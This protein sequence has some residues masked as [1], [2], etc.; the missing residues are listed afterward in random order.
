[1]KTRVVTDN[2][3]IKNLP[4]TGPVRGTDGHVRGT[5]GPV[6]GTSPL[7]IAQNPFN[8]TLSSYGFNVG[9]RTDL[10]R[11]R[12]EYCFESTVSEER[13]HWA[14]LSSAANSVSSATNSVSSRLHTN[15]RLRGTHWARSLKLNKPRKTHWVRCLKPYSPETVFGPFPT[16]RKTQWIG[17]GR[18]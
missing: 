8:C 9:V 6:T 4:C 12:A 10:Y 2:S 11:K 17:L 18:T 16:L 14:S 5:E 3:P 15:N 7:L 1:M 13:T